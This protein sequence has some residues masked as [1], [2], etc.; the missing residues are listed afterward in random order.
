MS[1]SFYKICL[2]C[3]LILGFMLFYQATNAQ[4]NFKET[5][6]WQEENTPDMGGRSTLL[7]FKDGKIIY[8][9]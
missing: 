2:N 8:S 6:N 5:A 7:I 1:V 3:S 9:N 4:Y